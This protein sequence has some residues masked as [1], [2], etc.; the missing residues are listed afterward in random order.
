M[1]QQQLLLIMLGVIL[2]GVAIVVGI[3]VFNA[4]AI[5]QKRTEVINECI[6]LASD[7]Q[8]YFRKPTSFGGGGN[9]FNG[10][11]IPREYS[12]TEVGS[13]KANVT[14]STEVKIT[15]TGNEIANGTDSVKVELIVTP[16]DYATTIIN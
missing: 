16:M 8:L 12:T 15:G 14:S 2:V 6:Q 9:S 5:D 3:G 1:G 13:F 11:K 7:A 10:Y 4:N